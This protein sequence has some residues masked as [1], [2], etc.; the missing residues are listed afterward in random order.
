VRGKLAAVGGGDKSHL[1]AV[2]SPVSFAS[3]KKNQV[4]RI[5]WSDL[6][7]P[8]AVAV[9]GFYA[10][11]VGWKSVGLDMGGYEDFC[12]MPAGA[13][14]PAAGI[15]HA[16]GVN[17]DLPAQW[18]VYITVANLRRALKTCVAKGGTIVTPE[19]AVGDAKMAV[20]RDPAGAVAA[21][22]QP[23]KEK[24]A[25]KATAKVKSAKKAK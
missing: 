14:K 5:L 7:V 12:M 15:C 21:L 23:A 20:I 24:P 11:V 1:P 17:K 10:A 22:F 9:S 13:K 8:D 25:K 6:T 18:L 2:G 3:M 19:R 16:R 4:G